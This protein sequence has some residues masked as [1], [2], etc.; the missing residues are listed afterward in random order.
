MCYP[1]IYFS[2]TRYGNKMIAL[3][4]LCNF[5]LVVSSA[6]IL[7]RS[8]LT[9]FSSSSPAGHK[10]TTIFR[11]KVLSLAE[12]WVSLHDSPISLS[13]AI[14]VCRHII[15]GRPRFLFPGGVHLSATLGM[16]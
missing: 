7:W 2:K 9:Y 12:A 5:I 8:V 6:S 11:H 13:S 15:F 10:A 14:T 4:T 16:A 1:G 3:V